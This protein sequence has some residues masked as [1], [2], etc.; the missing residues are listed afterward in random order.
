MHLTFHTKFKICNVDPPPPHI[1]YVNPPIYI[2]M[3][4]FE[5]RKLRHGK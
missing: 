5:I 2:Y 3:Y 1:L 4:V